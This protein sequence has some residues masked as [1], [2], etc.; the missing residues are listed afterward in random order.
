MTN[1]LE[2]TLARHVQQLAA[3]IGARPVGAAAN[4]AAGDYIA[5]E[6][7][8]V[9]LEIEEQPFACTAW[10][11]ASVV[12]E[13]QGE[14][15]PAA[16]NSFSAPCDVAGPLLVLRT[17]AELAA[18]ELAGKIALLCG[19]LVSP[20]PPPKS[21][22]LASDRD[23]RIIKLLESKGP[24]AALTVQNRLG[25]L[26]RVLEDPDFDIPSATVNAFAGLKLARQAGAIAQLRID[27]QR[28]PGTGRNL[29]G[30]KAGQ[31][32]S[33][34]IFCAHYDTK[35]DTP[36]ATDNAGGVAV[37]LALAE[38]LAQ[39][40]S[41]HHLEFVAFGSEDNVPIG[42]DEYVRQRGDDFSQVVAAVNIDGAGQ[43]L[44]ADSVAVIA[45]STEFQELVEGARSRRPD[46]ITAPPWPES[47]HST[48]AR[49]G[50]P[51]LAFT[52]LGAPN[53]THL[54]TDTVEWVSAAKLARL[55]DFIGDIAAAL[56]A[57]PPAWGR[58]Q[59]G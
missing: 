59:S 40:E 28:T 32:S 35:F 49:R 17:E 44:G 55:V 4:R 5:A 36:G 31:E 43:Q 20:P 8:R 56:Q 21:W 11:H 54:R 52:S 37:L 23:R 22:F 24:L 1:T 2:D 9:G 51:S 58:E 50:V 34:L 38:R 14:K 26:E 12:L 46:L 30:H 48:F 25:E 33:R 39:T 47:N 13:I 16:P 18:A 57:R 27:A 6:F 53:L 10:E 3:V 15:V 19:E 42:D 7:R 45:A 29:I 41:T